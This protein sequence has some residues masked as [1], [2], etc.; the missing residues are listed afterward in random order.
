M[1]P[2]NED[3]DAS[4]ANGGSMVFILFLTIGL[5]GIVWSGLSGHV[6]SFDQWMRARARGGVIRRSMP[7]V[8]RPG[9]GHIC[10]HPGSCIQTSNKAG[11]ASAICSKSRPVSD[12]VG[13]FLL[14][15][16]ITITRKTC[17]TP[18]FSFGVLHEAYANVGGAITYS[19]VSG[20]HD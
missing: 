18:I 9:P 16:P 15:C 11:G 19:Q 13:Y 3:E 5:N 14:G 17:S 4:W 10:S 6:L 20:C 7:L 12:I 8:H 1:G 2:W